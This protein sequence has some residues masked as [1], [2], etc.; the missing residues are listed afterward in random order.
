MSSPCASR[1]S[2]FSLVE[3]LAVI[4]IVLVLIGI[5]LPALRGAR[6]DAFRASCL[7]QVRQMAVAVTAYASD[8]QDSVPFP[9]LRANGPGLSGWTMPDGRPV[10]PEA[11]LAAGD[12]WVQPILDSYGGSFI[13]SALLCPLDTRS[14][15]TAEWAAVQL[16]IEPERV[17]MPL[18]R[19]ISRAFYTRPDSLARDRPTMLAPEDARVARLFEVVHPSA[20]AFVLEEVPFHPK[21]A[22]MEPDQNLENARLTVSGADGAVAVRAVADARHPALVGVEAPAHTSAQDQERFESLQRA[23]V[24]FHHTRDG[25]RGLDW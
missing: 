17:W 6:I 20:K 15:P 25:V 23:M 11:P 12:F 4:G 8:S 7:G 21:R 19:P 10:P 24:A 9:F 5:L 22:G 18:A 16:G 2:G 14:V 1:R 3:L 13:A